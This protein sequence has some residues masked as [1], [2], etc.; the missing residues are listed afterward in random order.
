MS[1][2]EP[3]VRHLTDEELLLDYYEEASSTDRAHVQAHLEAC[4]ECR[5]LDAELRAVLTA[6]ET[7]P[8]DE[9]PSGFEREMW[10][11]IE[12]LLPVGGARSWPWSL[13]APR[14]AVAAGMAAL[15]VAA[16]AL[17]R[18]WD[19]Q[20]VSVSPQVADEGDVNQRLLESEVEDHFERSR[21]VLVDLV[22]DD[23]AAAD[24]VSSGR[25]RAA[26]LVAAGRL[27]R[28]SSESGRNPDM[29]DLLEDLER[30]LMEV[31][32]GSID[33]TPDEVARLRERIDDQDLLLRLRVVAAEMRERG[34]RGQQ[35]W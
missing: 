34:Q 5:A 27:Y 25:A 9:P 24:L 20:G 32:N 12:P 28:Q 6:V 21:R 19:P 35:T 33:T 29:G 10:A 16:F 15:M 13:G 26:D 14:W 8:L 17:G 1:R 18:I 2:H 4:E 22:N 31:A 3:T 7:T 11:R 30:V 23:V